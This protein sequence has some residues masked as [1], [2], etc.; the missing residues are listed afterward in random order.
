MLGGISSEIF[1]PISL[2]LFVGCKNRYKNGTDII[3]LHA[4]FVGDW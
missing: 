3:Y 4:K 2:K 1:G